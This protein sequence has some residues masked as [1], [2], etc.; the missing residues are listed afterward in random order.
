[1]VVAD[2]AD[3]V[4]AAAA[5]VFDAVEFAF[6][7]QMTEYY[8]GNKETPVNLFRESLAVVMFDDVAPAAAWIVDSL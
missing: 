5:V 7:D 8:L 3:A 6:F 2:V 1:M 4:A